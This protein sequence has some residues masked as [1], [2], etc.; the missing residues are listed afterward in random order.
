MNGWY[1]NDV[2]TFMSKKL[3]FTEGFPPFTTNFELTRIQEA[4]K[5]LDPYYIATAMIEERRE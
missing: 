4:H 2:G 1:G 5:E 3:L